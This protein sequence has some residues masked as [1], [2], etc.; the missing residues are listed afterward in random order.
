MHFSCLHV[1]IGVW[2]LSDE[3]NNWNCDSSAPAT[4]QHR[5]V[6]K[7][8]RWESWLASSMHFLDLHFYY[9]VHRIKS[10]AKSAVCAEILLSVGTLRFEAVFTMCKVLNDEIRVLAFHMS[11]AKHSWI[12]EAV[13]TAERGCVLSSESMKVLFICT[14]S[15][16]NALYDHFG[17]VVGDESEVAN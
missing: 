11:R 14:I 4:C 13:L 8:R 5:D 9:T 1:F 6:H 10:R 17:V 7:R 2:C 12:I 16:K 3:K 15:P